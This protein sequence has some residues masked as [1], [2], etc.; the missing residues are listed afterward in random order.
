MSSDEATPGATSASSTSTD[1]SVATRTETDA[2]TRTPVRHRFAHSRALLGVLAVTLLAVGMR[3]FALGGRI[4]HW[5]EGRVGYWILRYHESGYHTYRPIV[6]GPFL[7]VVNDWLF[8]LIP[9]SDFAARLPVAL[10]GGLLPLGAWLFRERLRDTEVVALAAILAVNPLLVYYSR[11][12]RNDVLVAAF[13]LFALGFVVRGFDTGRLGYAFPAAASLGLAFTTKENA[14]LYVLCFLGAGV[15]LADH[16]LLRASVRGGSVRGVLVSRWPRGLAARF[17]AHGSSLGRGVG[18]VLATLVGSLLLFLLV[19]TFFYAPRPDLWQALADPGKLPGVIEAGTV[20]ATEAFID[21]WADGGHQDHA[22]LPYLHDFL[23]T[24]V[25]G[26]PA[27]IGFGLLG[28]LV[29]RYGLSGGSYREFVAFATYWGLASIAGYPLATDI[30]APW[31]VVHAVVPL[32]IPAAVGVGFVVDAGREA[33][34]A[35]D[36]VSVG[37][38][39]LVVLAAVGGVSAANVAYFNS[40]EDADKQVL[41]WAQPHN[42]LKPTLHDVERVVEAH[43]GT[44][45]LFYGTTAPSDESEELFYV[46]NESSLLTPPPGGPAWHDRLPL[47]WYLERY[48][49]NVTS[50]PPSASVEEATA[51]APPVVFAKGYDRDELEDELD[52]YVVREHEFRLWNDDVV[53]FIDEDA[54]ERA[55]ETA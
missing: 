24:F 46:E 42:D 53:V 10:V 50:S 51:D 15:L 11:F 16:R 30:Q 54:L 4:F 5:D 36:A 26:A 31:A 13:S 34:A 18:R 43:E 9:V 44:D 27:L 23:E 35:E 22:Y 48:D 3:V 8:A 12:M 41:Q 37:L 38:A 19:F 49:A 2:A 55:N 47:P 1:G 6:H 7:P 25:Y 52:G 39:A 29:D 21:T 28:A 20:G 40:T 45:V 17:R 14:V 32:A 33:L